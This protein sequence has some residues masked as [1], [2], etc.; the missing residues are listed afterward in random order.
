MKFDFEG[1][2][3]KEEGSSRVP[4]SKESNGGRRRDYVFLKSAWRMVDSTEII[5]SKQAGKPASLTIL[6]QRGSNLVF[7][8]MKIERA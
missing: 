7:Q 2:G 4:R 6:A 5:H 3:K 8:Q 1:E